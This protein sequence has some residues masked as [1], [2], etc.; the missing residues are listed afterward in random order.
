MHPIKV[1]TIINN[2]MTIPRLDQLMFS[3]EKEFKEGKV[4][5]DTKFHEIHES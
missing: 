5:Q 3:M 4:L 1:V 2:K